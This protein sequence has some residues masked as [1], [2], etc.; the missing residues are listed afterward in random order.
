M[1]RGNSATRRIQARRQPFH[2]PALGVGA[3]AVSVQ[4]A[5]T[6]SYSG[7]YH[8]SYNPQNED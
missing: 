1:S 8:I 5:E 3:G 4:S 7:D 2:G 6:Q